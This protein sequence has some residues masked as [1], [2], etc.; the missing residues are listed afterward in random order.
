MDTSSKGGQSGG[1]QGGSSALGYH[2]ATRAEDLLSSVIAFV[3][4]LVEARVMLARAQLVINPEHPEQ[5]LDV[6]ASCLRIQPGNSGAHLLSASIA[7]GLDNMRLAASSL[8]QAL[9]Y[10]FRVRSSPQYHLLKS[11]LLSRQGDYEGA[12]ETL[13]SAFTI[14]GVRSSVTK[15]PSGGRR[16]VEV[17]RTSGGG[18]NASTVALDERVALYMEA[19]AVLAALKRYSEAKALAKDARRMFQGTTGETAIVI[20][21]SQILVALGNDSQALRLLDDVPLNSPSI[22]SVMEAKAEIY[23]TSRRDRNNFVRCY[24]QLV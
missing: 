14:P 12:Y 1:L 5:T 17:T 4:S 22:A 3:P 13:E 20:S 8:E 6:L 19:V 23:L 9:S 16:A 7:L 18:E 21:L 2:A 24:E 10:D 11:Q 15:A